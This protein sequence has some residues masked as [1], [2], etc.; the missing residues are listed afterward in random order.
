MIKTGRVTKL[1][2]AS[3]KIL[4]KIYEDKEITRCELCGSD[5]A[6][7][8]HHRHKRRWYRDCP[9]K[10]SEFNQTLLL[11]CKCHDLCE[12]SRSMTE[13]VFGRLRGEE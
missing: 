10:L 12:M 3:N 4:K 11:C 6:L 2:I 13:D 1:N 7:S 9:E 5:W 8:F